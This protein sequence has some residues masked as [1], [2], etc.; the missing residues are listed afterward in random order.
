[1]P[2]GMPLE[3]T[4]IHGDCREVLPSIPS[5]SI[6]LTVTSPPYYQLRD[7]GGRQIGQEATVDEYIDAL[8]SVLAELHRVTC[9][10][11]SCFVVLG[12]TYRNNR[13]CLIPHRTA[14]CA[15]EIG[16][17]VRNDI[18][19]HKADPAPGS[20]KS[21]WRS[22]HEHVLFLSKRKRGYVFNDDSIRQPYSESTLRRWGSGQRYGGKK[23][24]D[25]S[26][27]AA[28][29]LRHGKS[30]RL[31]PA[32]AIPP[33]VWRLANGNCDLPHYAVFPKGLI[34]PLIKACSNPD[35]WVLDP[36]AGVGTTC[37]LAKNLGR[38]CIGIESNLEFAGL[39]VEAL[40][41]AAD[42]LM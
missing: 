11:G 15:D 39:A 32:G 6:Q 26:G 5:E 28:P 18:I 1:M 42:Q 22:S 37:V 4:I 29:A 31:N 24:S 33:D 40:K 8:R 35:D 36:F 23:S 7:Y 19:W 12:D 14:I 13:L 34:E 41:T 20:P 2:H 10:Q 30:F 38:Q 3:S 21:R 27:G 25:R 17:Y 9:K 16:W